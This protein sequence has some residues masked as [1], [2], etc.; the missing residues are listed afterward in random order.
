MAGALLLLTLAGISGAA[1]GGQADIWPLA[2]PS[3]INDSDVVMYISNHEPRFFIPGALF[4]PRTEFVNE[5]NTIRTAPE[6]AGMLG[7]NGISENDSLVLYGDCLTCGDPTLIYMIMLYLGH[8]KVRILDGG[9]DQWI[10]EGLP[11][12]MSPGRR[13]PSSYTPTLRPEILASYDYVRNSGAQIVDARSRQEFARESIPG[14]VNIESDLVLND[15]RI[16]DP[17][18]LAGLFSGLYKE[19]PVVAYSQN[20]GKG[21]LVCFALQL[22]GYDAR[23]YTW[24]DWVD[25]RPPLMVELVRIQ[26]LPNP[27]IPGPVRINVVLQPTNVSAGESVDETAS[28][29]VDESAGESVAE[30]INQSVNE[31][32]NESVDGPAGEAAAL[33]DQ[34]RLKVMGCVTC[35]PITVY[36]GGSLSR[37]KRAGV[38][39]GSYGKA[40]AQPVSPDNQSLTVEVGVVSDDQEVARVALSPVGDYEFAGSWDASQ[41]EPGFYNLTLTVSWEGRSRVFDDALSIEIIRPLNRANQSQDRF[42][43]LSKN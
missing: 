33:D 18:S 43:K 42:L 24:R 13:P 12:E 37:D 32:S 21:S 7:E 36:T 6:L 40:A 30:S 22:M 34:T 11:V 28:E 16:R 2:K 5:D 20:G 14:A 1:D 17:E 23:L 4:V 29:S 10:E 27:S 38:V 39:L 19:R 3:S 31:S 9:I 26:A 15:S 41:A 35:E 8:Q 25:N